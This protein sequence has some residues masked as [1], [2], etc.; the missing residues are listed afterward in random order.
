M[1]E[2][3]KTF[4]RDI[5]TMTKIFSTNNIKKVE[6]GK[7]SSTGKWAEKLVMSLTG[8]FKTKKSKKGDVEV[9]IDAVTD[10]T[11]EVKSKS[12]A[13]VYEDEYKYTCNQV[14]SI[15]M[16]PLVVATVNI[17]KFGC[18]FLVI[19]AIEV[20]KKVLLKRGQH[21]RY[22]AMSCANLVVYASDS[23]QYGCS[24]EDL[25]R[26]IK[27]AYFHTINHDHY[28]LVLFEIE[29]HRRMEKMVEENNIALGEI[30]NEK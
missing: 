21:V 9:P 27:D 11:V 18:D 15:S 5:E 24:S 25:Y 4:G 26:K 28:D 13:I 2:R 6:I 16:N 23:E 17:P 8:G 7:I 30:L 3:K 20:M 19:P 22:D 12:S 29:S 14:R 10:I 1:Q